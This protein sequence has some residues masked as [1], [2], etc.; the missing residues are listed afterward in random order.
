MSSPAGWLRSAA[1]PAY[2]EPEAR[3][4]RAP[5]TKRMRPAHWIALDC[6]VGVVAG[7]CCA[8][9]VGH[10]STPGQARLPMVVLVLLGVFF[11]VALRRRAPVVAF[12]ALM[13][14]GTV[15]AR[16]S[17]GVSALIF[18]AAAYV[19][20]TLTVET[21]KRTGAAA[22]ALL[23]AT[24]VGVG[25]TG[26]RSVDARAAAVQGTD[27][28]VFIPVALA[29]VIA[30]MTGY[31]V[32]QRR[33]YV[34]TLQQQAASSAVAEERLR[35]ARELHDVVAHSMSV[36][37]V[38][39]GYGQ[40][41]IDSSPDGAR[42]ALGAIQATSRDALEEMRR[43]LGV[44][45]Q[46]DAGADGTGTGTPQAGESGQAAGLTLPAAPALPGSGSDGAPL[47]FG[48]AAGA[49]APDLAGGTADACAAEGSPAKAGP[50]GWAAAGTGATRTGTR[51]GDR[52]TGDRATGDRATGDRVTRNTDAGGAGRRDTGARDP[53]HGAAAV[54][55]SGGAAAS[56]AP[57]APAPGLAALDRLISRTR[58]AGVRLVLEVSGQA[59]P[60]L[61]GVDLSA[62]RII[63]EALT[64]VVKHAGTGADCVVSLT[65]TDADLVIR[66][67]DDGGRAAAAGL[68]GGRL[69]DMCATGT[70]HGIIG[71]RERV[72]LCGGT[73]AAGPRPEGGFQVTAT[74]PLPAIALPAPPPAGPGVINA[75]AALSL[76]SARP[77]ALTEGQGGRR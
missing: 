26:P 44:L 32:R 16:L 1:Y 25:I 13:I 63:Q 42:E 73:F 53:G 66:V 72:N 67:T 20:Y 14:M 70:G 23:L 35:I 3:P 12:G 68:G 41:V 7:L 58:G 54:S 21:R 33:R 10:H 71:M 74:L 43:M 22:I 24:L 46:Q 50:V 64:N 36:I 28:G 62:F 18:L 51:S 65:Y 40:Y 52:A 77:A 9:A 55:V 2:P 29:G 34:V 38:Q 56:W 45:R 4:P 19:L 27:T 30:W 6:A 8:A 15:V 49:V 59:R 75:P 31:S 37:A 47:A 39:A 76:T 17:P 60:A 48:P 69:G 5:L 61:A 11:S 57:L